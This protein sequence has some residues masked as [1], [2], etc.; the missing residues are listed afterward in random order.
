MVA[1]LEI[2]AFEEADRKG[3]KMS[4]VWDIVRSW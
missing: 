4:S 2:R 1:L 3:V